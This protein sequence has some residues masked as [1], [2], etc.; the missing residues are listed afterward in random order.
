MRKLLVFESISVDGY[1]TVLADARGGP[2]DAGG[3]DGMNAAKKY[4]ASG[5]GMTATL[6]VA[7]IELAFDRPES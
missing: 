4:V 7:R 5:P 2:A 1:F 3:G 6:P